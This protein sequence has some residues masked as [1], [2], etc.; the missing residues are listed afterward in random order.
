MY[1]S[2]FN[3]NEQVK[4][5]SF[6][7]RLAA[8]MANVRTRA[9]A[10]CLAIGLLVLVIQLCRVPMLSAALDAQ[11][12]AVHDKFFALSNKLDSR[13]AALSDEILLICVDADSARRLGYSNKENVPR[14]IY[15]QLLD[16]LKAAG[17]NVI[18]LD[19]PLDEQIANTASLSNNSSHL[20]RSTNLIKSPAL[21][22]LEFTGAG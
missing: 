22:R 2:D 5:R 18:G 6:K 15:A 12:L 9:M 17:A 20:G 4:G 19:I 21:D 11:E 13:A 1:A 16:Q 7:V 3:N 10:I 14:K 8:E